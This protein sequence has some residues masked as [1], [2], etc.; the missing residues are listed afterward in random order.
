MRSAAG[1][2]LVPAGARAESESGRDV[3]V[4]SGDRHLRLVVRAGTQI[5][6]FWLGYGFFSALQARIRPDRLTALRD[7]ATVVRLDPLASG[8]LAVNQWV[9]AVPWLAMIAAA[10]YAVLLLVPPVTLVWLWAFHRDSYRSARN[11]L[12]L[13]TFA[14]LPLFMVFPVAPPRLY[15]P[16]ADDLVQVYGV[17]GITT[18]PSPASTVDLY[19]AMP[20]LDVAWAC[21]SAWAIYRVRGSRTP[22]RRWVWLLPVV[23]AL[24]VVA[25]ANHYL[26]DILAGALLTAGATCVLP[27]VDRR[28]V[29]LGTGVRRTVAHMYRRRD[30]RP[31]GRSD[32]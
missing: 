23:A 9:A 15:V 22:R 8:E 12:A 13:L 31:S 32:R 1:T 5:A 25:T 27:R 30:E 20:S 7:A 24:D 17:L 16:G 21:W 28:H 2:A 18:K 10:W 11:V 4:P 26:P 6:A 14:A 19:A 3:T 29:R